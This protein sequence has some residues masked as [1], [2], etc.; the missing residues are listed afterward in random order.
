M[1][2]SSGPLFYLKVEHNT[3]IH[4][5]INQAFY[6][7]YTRGRVLHYCTDFYFI[8]LHFYIFYQFPDFMSG[9]A[10]LMIGFVC[11]S[12]ILQPHAGTFRQLV[13]RLKY[14]LC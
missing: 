8:I 9:S 11:S 7:S 13:D 10:S 12:C 2:I 1:P 6:T 3:T 14:G 5:D 4:T